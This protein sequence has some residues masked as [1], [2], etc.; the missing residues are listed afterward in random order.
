[1]TN[2]SDYLYKAAGTRT[3]SDLIEGTGINHSTMSRYLSGERKM[4]VS[5]VVLMSEKYQIP[6]LDGMV[7]AEYI[8][9][10]HADRERGRYGLATMS[11]QDLAAEVL[12][13]LEAASSVELAEEM[14]KPIG[15]V[16]NLSERRRRVTADDITDEDLRPSRDAAAYTPEEGEEP[17][18]DSYD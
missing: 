5:V 2:Y 17:D 3:I 4:P 9:E 15:N 10:E 11:D 14:E 12:R 6:L 8:T 16:S 1:M 18:Y 13:R 7:A